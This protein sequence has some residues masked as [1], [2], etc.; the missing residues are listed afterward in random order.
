M[1]DKDISGVME[2]LVE[3][4]GVSYSDVTKNIKGEWLG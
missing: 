2:T 4:S 3:K 1:V